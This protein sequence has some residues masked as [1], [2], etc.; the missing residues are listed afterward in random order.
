MKKKVLTKLAILYTFIFVTTILIFINLKSYS[1]DR[2]LLSNK[3]FVSLFDFVNDK[4]EFISYCVFTIMFVLIF[5][6]VKYILNKYVYFKNSQKINKIINIA[7]LVV[8]LVISEL[9][10]TDSS[11]GS[12][13]ANKF[14]Y[15]LIPVTVIFVPLI[16]ND[17]VY[18]FLKFDKSYNVIV[19]AIILSIIY[20]LM[21]KT[22]FMT[23][24]SIHH[25]MAY[26]YPITK[27]NFGYTLGI[28]F[29]S[30][31]GYY[32]YFYSLVMKIFH[33]DSVLNLGYIFAVLT[34]ISFIFVAY[35]I[36]KSI[37]NKG[38]ALLVFIACFYTLIIKSIYNSG[39]SYLQYTPHRLLFPS[40][41]LA[42]IFHLYNNKMSNK[43]IIF[44]YIILSLALFFNF[45]TGLI[46]LITYTIS[47]M[48]YKYNNK[49]SIK[50]LI[51]F[52]LLSL[53]SIFLY[54]SI[55]EL[56][57][58]I[59]TGKLIEISNITF[60][61][62]VFAKDGFMML[63]MNIRE[64][65]LLLAIIVFIVLGFILS[66]M[67]FLDNEKIKIEDYYMFTLCILSIGLF[68]YFVGRSVFTNF[69]VGA[70]PIFILFGM[71]IDEKYRE[72]KYITLPLLCIFIIITCN[73]FS[74]I[75]SKPGYAYFK[76]NDGLYYVKQDISD[77]D[78]LYNIT[79]KLE[80]FFYNDAYY[81]EYYKI[82]NKLRMSA[83]CDTFTYKQLVPY[84]EYLK[85]N[86]E[87]IYITNEFIL[88]SIKNKYLSDY[89][90]ILKKYDIYTINGLMVLVND[91][92]S[93]DVKKLEY[94]YEYSIRNNDKAK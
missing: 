3:Y 74:N 62:N 32:P 4:N 94:F 6:L 14:Y 27:I 8:V 89:K 33:I 92:Y 55:V 47:I 46:C 21:P 15:Y 58:Y 68:I 84:I 37:K 42:Y 2:K 13:F 20:F 66:K 69:L 18:S 51:P 23:Q 90:Y 91:K 10:V 44:G 72:N 93:N 53:A 49:S 45:E 28:D 57:T 63:R 56:I 34:I 26:T 38:V 50:K 5:L 76:K 48:F 60:G 43:G 79:D 75:I 30:L 40:M 25:Y 7:F 52:L 41:I 73:F 86:E 59:R 31:Y 80:F 82:P 19:I 64:I 67:K 39:A 1:V 24:G 81:Y 77:L 87:A 83:Y 65:W 71:I 36:N 22:Y 11:F 9:C 35:S 85:N 12:L 17:K 61:S 29:L 88:N 78:K 70:Y 16:Y 54:L